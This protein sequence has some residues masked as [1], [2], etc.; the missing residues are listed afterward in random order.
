MVWRITYRPER[1]LTEQERAEQLSGLDAHVA[2]GG[3]LP[4]TAA[5]GSRSV[6]ALNRANDYGLDRQAERTTRYAGVPGVWGA[7]PRLHRGDGGHHGDGTQEHL[8]SSDL[9]VIKMRRLL[10][11][12]ARQLE[13][14][15]PSRPAS[16]RCPG[17]RPSRPACTSGTCPGNRSP[18]P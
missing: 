12:V 4:P 1:P 14:A 16:G 3:Y 10:I 17:S 11:R 8:A 5:P 18:R 9:P 15:G 2:P 7:G 13:A 6:P